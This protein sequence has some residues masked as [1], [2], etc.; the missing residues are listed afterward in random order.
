MVH[1]NGK[2]KS[3]NVWYL[4]VLEWNRWVVAA[5][6]SSGR[7]AGRHLAVPL[8]VNMAPELKMQQVP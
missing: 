3:Q 5:T 7:R 1:E 4:S 2:N 6:V 8:Q